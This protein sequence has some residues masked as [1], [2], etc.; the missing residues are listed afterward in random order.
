M[1]NIGLAIWIMKTYEHYPTFS[2]NEGKTVNVFSNH[3]SFLNG[4]ELE[5]QSIML[6]SS[7]SKYQEEVDY[8]WDNYFGLDLCS[9]LQGKSV[10]DLGS[11]TGGRSVAWYERYKLRHITGI[12]VKQEYVNAAVQFAAKRNIRADFKLGFGESLPFGEDTFDAILSFDVFEHVQDL[13][14][15]LDEC[16]RVLKPGGRLFLVFPSYFHPLE[17]HLSL[18]TKVPCIHW[19]F[20]G[21][22]LVKAYYQILEERGNDAYW[23]KRSSPDLKF[24][25]RGHTINGTTLSQFKGLIKVRNWRVIHQA[26]KPIGSIGRHIYKKTT[27]RLISKLFLP[28][29]FIPGLRELFLHRIVFILEKQLGEGGRLNYAQP[30]HLRQISNS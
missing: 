12:D 27:L 24:W 7:E 9:F 4:S 8:P 18:V 10:L 19:F 20:S 1:D 16:F 26:K 25:E 21:H 3:E 22:T 17:H 5:K 30:T 15:T 29:T 6:K 2:I 28:L 11:F 13:R 14:K 23:Y